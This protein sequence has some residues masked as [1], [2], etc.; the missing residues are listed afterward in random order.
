MEDVIEDALR[1]KAF[2]NITGIIIL[3]KDMKVLGKEIR[4]L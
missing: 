2:D 3:L 4:L 1:K